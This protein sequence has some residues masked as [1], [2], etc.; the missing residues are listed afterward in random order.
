MT[1]KKEP[2]M[3]PEQAAQWKR[4]WAAKRE[5]ELKELRAMTPAQKFEQ[6][7]AL[8]ESIRD[9][10]EDKWREAEVQVIRERWLK[11]KRGSP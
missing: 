10:P 6:L 4:K 9:F 1:E 11:I 8:M 7:A 2:M 5:F 3:T